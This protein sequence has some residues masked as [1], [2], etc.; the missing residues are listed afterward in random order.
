MRASRHLHEL[1]RR[2]LG[3]PHRIHYFHQVEDPYSHLAVQTLASLC[4]RYSIELS[5]HVASPD[6]GPN[7]PEPELLAALARRDCHAIAPRY[8]LE[9]PATGE[10]PSREQVRA[11]QRALVAAANED[12]DA[13]AKRAVAL[14][15][16]LWSGDGGSL[17][18]Q[19]ETQP[20]ASD[21]ETERAIHEARRLRTKRGHYSGAMFHYAGEW[22]WGVD[23]LHHLERRFTEL[24]A[25]RDDAGIRY[26]RPDIPMAPVAR[27][28]EMT[29]E[30]F[31][32]LRSPYT[33]ICFERVLE[34][35]ER[36]GVGLLVRPVLPMVMRGVPAPFAKGKYIMFDTAR[37][38]EAM[39]MS[40]GRV[41]DPIGEPVR[42]GYSLWPLACERGCGPT[43]LA[44]FLRAAFA[45]GIDTGTEAG[46]RHVVERAGLSWDEVAEHLGDTAWEA[47]LEENRLAML[48]E[49]GQ[50]GVPSFRLTGPGDEP[51]LCTWGQDR[52]WLLAREISRRGGD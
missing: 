11:V 10:E 51:P 16:A 14:G 32:S 47:E 22:Y 42:R 2:L 41:L 48:G 31:P 39:G 25:A 19:C 18:A 8:G 17:K 24:G 30:I 49:L 46:L 4:E 36:T 29:L 23:R 13:F 38:A 6:T 35:A 1:A 7:Q 44:S 37:E 15:T 21:E 27:A 34:L 43:L 33:A 12:T 45:E 5:A 26:R 9:F 52:L 40:F 3:A 50:W 28:S 20:V